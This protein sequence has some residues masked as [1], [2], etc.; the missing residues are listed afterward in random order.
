MPIVAVQIQRGVVGGPGMPPITLVLFHD[1]S[2]NAYG[3]ARVPELLL[4]QRTQVW[5]RRH[6]SVSVPQHQFIECVN[7]TEVSWHRT[8]IECV[9]WLCST[10]D[11]EVYRF[12]HVDPFV[13][14]AL[15]RMMSE[16]V[17]ARGSPYWRIDQQTFWPPVAYM[18]PEVRCEHEE[19]S[20]HWV[21][22]ATEVDIANAAAQSTSVASY[23]DR[24]RTGEAR[25]RQ[26]NEAL[27]R[28]ANAPIVYPYT[29]EQI[30]GPCTNPSCRS[31]YVSEGVCWDCGTVLIALAAVR[32][33]D[34]MRRDLESVHE[35]AFEQEVR[36]LLAERDARLRNGQIQ[37]FRPEPLVRR[38]PDHPNFTEND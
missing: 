5:L 15:Q 2:V 30:N 24:S 26:R 11:W 35:Q 38:R 19:A 14:G 13:R 10:R 20:R 16:R 23:I 29:F 31:I 34:A 3:V 17:V 37:A 8:P 21:R 7:E 22:R 36:R 4:R 28:Q 27:R 6:H 25:R 32:T 12:E 18:T 33:E 1:T 9:R